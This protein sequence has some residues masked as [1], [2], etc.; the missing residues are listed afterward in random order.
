MPH[1]YEIL[2]AIF[3]GIAVLPTF[4]VKLFVSLS[5]RPLFVGMIALTAITDNAGS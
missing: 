1:V 2:G 5:H 4:S 3:L